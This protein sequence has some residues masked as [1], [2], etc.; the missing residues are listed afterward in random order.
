MRYVIAIAITIVL[1][2]GIVIAIQAL[3]VFFVFFFQL[4]TNAGYAMDTLF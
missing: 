2:I 1:D 3:R 4:L